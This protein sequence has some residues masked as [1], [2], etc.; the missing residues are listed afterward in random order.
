MGGM[1]VTMQQHQHQPDGA[2]KS[3]RMAKAQTAL[4]P[5][6]FM[7]DT[8]D[9]IPCTTQATSNAGFKRRATPDN[10]EGDRPQ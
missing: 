10:S 4:G 9:A 5:S 2:W 1:L 7:N 6:V 3:T 8:K